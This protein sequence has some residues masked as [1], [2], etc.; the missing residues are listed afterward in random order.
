MT[1]RELLERIDTYSP[2]GSV[3]MADSANLDA[4]ALVHQAEDDDPPDRMDGMPRVMDVWQVKE[5]LDGLRNLLG[6]Q[7]GVAPSQIQLFD[8][9]LAY[10]K[11][12]A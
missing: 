2:E 9:Y 8:R 11:N 3:Y 1:L 12:D 5:A 6:Q 10:L 4:S 7:S